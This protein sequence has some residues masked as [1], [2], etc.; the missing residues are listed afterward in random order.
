ML[1]ATEAG[2]SVLESFDFFAQNE[3]GFG[4]NP[5]NRVTDLVPQVLILSGQIEI[6]NLDFCF[7]CWHSFKEILTAEY[8]EMAPRWQRKTADWKYP[9]VDVC[10]IRIPRSDSTSSQE[11]GAQAHD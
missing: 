4:R 1:Y 8:A 9:D 3:C 2:E 7:S 10:A 5:V 11:S 6:R